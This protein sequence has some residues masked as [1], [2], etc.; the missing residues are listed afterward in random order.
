[1]KQFTVSISVYDVHSNYTVDTNGYVVHTNDNTVYTPKYT[2]HKTANTANTGIY[3]V[4]TLDAWQG[5]S[6][7]LEFGQ[8]G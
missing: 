7:A 3:T 2:L 5:E 1:M 8:F 4:N 6:R